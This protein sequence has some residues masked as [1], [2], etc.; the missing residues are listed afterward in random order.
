MG[1]F[2]VGKP[3]HY[4]ITG[5][6]DCGRHPALQGPQLV[7][8]IQLSPHSARQGKESPSEETLLSSL[9]IILSLFEDNLLKVLL[10]SAFEQSSL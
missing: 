1:L 3:Y 6:A 7:Q 8:Q 9:F 2:D 4:T 5:L 10:I